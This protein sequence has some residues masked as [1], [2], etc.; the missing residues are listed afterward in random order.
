[1]N[2]AAIAGTLMLDS[3]DLLDPTAQSRAISLLTDADINGIARKGKAFRPVEGNTGTA[4][5]DTFV[6]ND[7]GT[8]Y[9][10]VF[11][12]SASSSATKSINL[13]RAGLNGSTTYT[14]TDQWGGSISSAAGT[15]NVT[16]GAKESKLYKLN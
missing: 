14:V 12:F 16:L 9:L 4:V 13:A 15:L 2:S 6:L 5:A 11:N 10:A 8:F 3:D 7:N 1:V